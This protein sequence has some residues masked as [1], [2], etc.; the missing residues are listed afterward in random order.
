MDSCGWAI[1]RRGWCCCM[2]RPVRVRVR[3]WRWQ[4]ASSVSMYLRGPTLLMTMPCR[5]SRPPPGQTVKGASRTYDSIDTPLTAAGPTDY[6]PALAKFEEFLGRAALP[7]ASALPLRTGRRPPP[8]PTPRAPAPTVAAAAA[9]ATTTA[10]ATGVMMVDDPPHVVERTRPALFAALRRYLQLAPPVRT[11]VMVVSDLHASEA[12]G[13]PLGPIP[14]DLL[15]S[16]RCTAV[17]FNPIAPTILTR[18][19]ERV[20]EG[21]TRAGRLRVRPSAEQ[22]RDLVANAAGDVR[23]A[24]NS[25]HIVLLDPRGLRPAGPTVTAALAM[26]SALLP[27]YQTLLEHDTL[28]TDDNDPLQPTRGLPGP[29]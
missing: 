3:R 20:V 7:A 24:V 5:R 11:L 29:R 18:A 25:L 16:P 14:T 1:R 13:N 9:A 4:P 28:T 2:G 15:Q 27:K 8:T 6:V 10:L 12:D 21:E 22:M 17:H 23:A 26:P 19:L